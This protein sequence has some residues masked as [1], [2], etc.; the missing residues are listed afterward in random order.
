MLPDRVSNPGPLTYESG[1]LK[2][3]QEYIC[4]DYRIHCNES[5]VAGKISKSSKSMQ[6]E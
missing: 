5:D 2:K 1:A 6:N 3:F 4:N